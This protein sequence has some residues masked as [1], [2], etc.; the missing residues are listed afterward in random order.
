M[1]NHNLTLA[2]IIARAAM[3]ALPNEELTEAADFLNQLEDL[4]D[5]K[6]SRATDVAKLIF[7]LE[8]V[9]GI[10]SKEGKDG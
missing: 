2:I 5:S 10:T 6:S 7:A 3:S 9:R 8:T 4:R 1:D